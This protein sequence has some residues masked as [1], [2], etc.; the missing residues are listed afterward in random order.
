MLPSNHKFSDATKKHLNNIKTFVE[1]M[2]SGL[3]AY[4]DGR[5]FVSI[6]FQDSNQ[7]EFMLQSFGVRFSED[8]ILLSGEVWV[9][10][11][12]KSKPSQQP[13]SLDSNDL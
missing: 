4:I 10:Q 1:I 7:T 13:T 3:N 9:V 5:K 2:P 11:E 12:S 6:N 8:L